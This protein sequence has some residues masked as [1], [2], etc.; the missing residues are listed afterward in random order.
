MLQHF[1][2]KYYFQEK[3]CASMHG[4]IILLVLLNC[5]KIRIELF[6]WRSLSGKSKET[7]SWTGG[8][9]LAPLLITK[10]SG[11]FR[12]KI[13]SSNVELDLQ[14]GYFLHACVALG[15]GRGRLF[16]SQKFK[17][18]RYYLYFVTISHLCLLSKSVEVF[19]EYVF[20]SGRR[21]PRAN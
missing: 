7:V 17:V 2:K 8:K 13:L 9:G 10:G 11:I 20:H 5:S 18:R 1:P 15:R 19:E 3:P 14:P 21:G 4:G 6:S 12:V 16:L